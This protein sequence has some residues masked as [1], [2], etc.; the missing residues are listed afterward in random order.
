MKVYHPYDP[1]GNL[2]LYEPHFRLCPKC[3]RSYP[4]CSRDKRIDH[5]LY[6]LYIGLNNIIQ[7]AFAVEGFD[8]AEF[9]TAAEES[10]RD[11]RSVFDVRGRADYELGCGLE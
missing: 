6:L 5:T 9:E 11:E 4:C 3:D 1:R 8:D 10:A 7:S 2:R